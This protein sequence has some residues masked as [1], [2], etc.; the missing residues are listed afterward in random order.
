[1]KQLT[2]IKAIR[3]KCLDCTCQQPKEIRECQIKTCALWPYRMGRRPTTANDL[4]PEEQEGAA[5]DAA[6]YIS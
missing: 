4:M 3:A 5:T 6:A 2:P 1:M